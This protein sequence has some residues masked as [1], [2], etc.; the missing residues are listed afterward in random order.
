MIFI[1]Q[2]NIKTNYQHATKKRTNHKR[3]GTHA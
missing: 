1:L 3:D 2:S